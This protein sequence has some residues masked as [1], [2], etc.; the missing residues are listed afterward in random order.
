MCDA[1]NGLIGRSIFFSS[2]TDSPIQ[3]VGSLFVILYI[4]FKSL[5]VIVGVDGDVSTVGMYQMSNHADFL[6][7]GEILNGPKV[8]AYMTIFQCSSYHSSNMII[9]K[10]E[11]QY[12]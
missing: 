10:R 4:E 9:L 6:W 1:K 2:L 7:D 8:G 3:I 11:S 5:G 12:K